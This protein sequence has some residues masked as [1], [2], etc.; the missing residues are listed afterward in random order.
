[1]FKVQSK[2]SVSYRQLARPSNQIYRIQCPVQN[3]EKLYLDSRTSDAHFTFESG[4]GDT[5]QPTARIGAHRILL[6]NN[7]D[8]FKGMF[9]G[10]LKENGNE[11]PMTDASEAAFKEFLQ[12][13]YLSEVE[14]HAENIAGLM[15]LGQKYKVIKCVEICVQFLKDTATA[16]NILFAMSL[17]ILYNHAD[18][19]KF[20][21]KFIIM[22]TDAVLESSG[23]L[24]CEQ[25]TLAYIV[26]ANL[27]ACSEVKLF[28][29]CMEWAKAK[30]KQNFLTKEI[31][32]EYL[33][34]LFYEIRFGA[35]TIQ[36]LCNLATKYD[37]VL[38][39]DFKT[40]TKL[41]VVPNFQPEK[42]N[43]RPRQIQLT[44][45]TCMMG[46]NNI[47]NDQDNEFQDECEGFDRS[48]FKRKN[49]AIFLTKKR[50]RLISSACNQ[51]HHDSF[52]SEED[53]EYPSPTE[54]QMPL[55]IISRKQKKQSE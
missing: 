53:M 54:R 7:S 46:R 22:N 30:S 9:Y 21:E 37:S 45:D 27:L 17:G 40:L 26:K 3:G 28:E 5:A 42:F 47:D 29:S 35:M 52:S 15:Y 11:F 39:N 4:H 18:L 13:F 24:E 50:L 16:D 8:V 6:A 38:S 51:M 19:L 48:N 36:E 34:E 33:G 20:C 12:F 43:I 44:E 55:R 31:V 2:M 14:L 49:E 1:M 25:Q 23:F 32:D 41:I 10:E